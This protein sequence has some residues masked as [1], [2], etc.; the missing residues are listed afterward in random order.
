MNE[1]VWYYIIIDAI[2][3]NNLSN[4]LERIFDSIETFCTF[5]ILYLYI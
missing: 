4:I 1:H 5:I 3:R 2:N